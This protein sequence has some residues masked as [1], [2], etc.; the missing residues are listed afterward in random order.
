MAKDL[1]PR[2]KPGPPA[3]RENTEF[4]RSLKRR[5]CRDV[6]R[7]GTEVPP[8]EGNDLFGGINSAAGTAGR[9]KL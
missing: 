1:S 6:A 7:G 2:L 3:E 9:L 5:L 8:F 4:F